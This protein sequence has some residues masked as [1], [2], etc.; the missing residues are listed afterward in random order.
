MRKAKYM[1]YVLTLLRIIFLR[2]MMRKQFIATFAI[3][4]L[5]SLVIQVLTHQ[6]IVAD[7]MAK[8][9]GCHFLF[10]LR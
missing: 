4:L 6:T 8:V 5:I 1:Y 3:L 9:S 2:A 10:L 7:S